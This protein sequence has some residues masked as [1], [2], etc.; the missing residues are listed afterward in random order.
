MIIVRQHLGTLLMFLFGE[1]RIGVV[2]LSLQSTTALV[3]ASRSRVDA[4]LLPSPA[5]LQVSSF[6]SSENH[7]NFGATSP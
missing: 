4:E 7:P 3:T 2:A 5:T 6:L 1:V